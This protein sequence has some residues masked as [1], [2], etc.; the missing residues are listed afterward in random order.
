MRKLFN[1]LKPLVAVLAVLI[2]LLVSAG[3]AR[4][5]MVK[6]DL[7]ELSVD[8]D[9]IV[10]G[11]I[12]N[13]TSHWSE[14][15][16]NIYTTVVVSVEE[17]IKGSQTQ[18]TVTIVVPGGQVDN[19]T[20]FVSDTPAFNLGEEALLFLK[21]LPGK[22]IPRRQIQPRF[23]E[24]SGNFQG[25]KDI[26]R[27]MV[28][29]I[30]VEA[31]EEEISAILEED[32]TDSSVDF[33]LNDPEF[34]SYNQYVYLGIRWPGSSPIV[35]YLVNASS[36]QTTQINAAASTWS[37]A[38]AAFDFHYAGS[39]SRSGQSAYNG[40]NEI[41]WYDL[42]TNNALAIASL[43]FSGSIIL[44][45]DMTFNTRY[46]WSTTSGIY[47][48][49]TVALHEFGHW[50]GLD[51]SPTY[52]SAIYFQY[53][54]TQHYLHSVDIAGIRSIYG[55]SGPAPTNDNFIGRITLSGSSGQTAE[56]NSNAT[57][58]IGEPNHAGDSGGRSV[59]W[60]WTAPANGRVEFDTFG[61]SFDTLLAVYSGTSLT[62]LTAIV[63]NDDYGGLY[64]SKIAFNTLEGT[65]YLIAVDGWAGAAGSIALNWQFT[66]TPCSIS[67]PSQPTGPNVGYTDTTYTFST[68]GSTCVNGHA[69]E[70]HF[71][72]GVGSVSDWSSS[73]D[74]S[75]VWTT[76]ETYQV[77]S[78]V[79]CAVDTEKVSLWSPPI[80]IVIAVETVQH[81]LTVAVEGNGT[82]NPS[83]GAYLYNEGSS[84]DLEAIPDEGWQFAKW[85]IGSEEIFSA[86]TTITLTGD[87]TALA[88]FTETPPVPGDLTGDDPDSDPGDP[89]D[90]VEDTVLTVEYILIIEVEG[91]G[92]T[93]PVAGNYPYEEGSLV[94]LE[95]IPDEGW[96]FDKWVIGSEEFKVESMA[97]TIDSDITLLAVF[98]EVQVITPDPDP[99]PPPTAETPP[100][101]IPNP[102][103]L[104][105]P[106]SPVQYILTLAIRGEGT[107]DPDPGLYNIGENAEIILTAKPTGGWRFEKWVI[108]GVESS[109]INVTVKMSGNKTATAHFGKFELGDITGDGEITV[110]D[111]V[112]VARHTLGMTSLTETQLANADVNGDSLVDIR[113]ITLIMRFALGIV[114]SFPAN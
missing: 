23:Y 114:D 110:S 3:E 63:S 75:R 6:M 13:A 18:N 7:E 41:M 34:V 26:N 10:I 30:P 20:Q 79:R 5:V 91:Q 9:S 92:S 94:D 57:K 21:E 61:S 36:A 47:D 56:N 24:L 11:T 113:D 68:G 25:K 103:V 89:A 42:G 60:A 17:N 111:V 45:T 49:Q 100:P 52:G 108:D 33:A 98:S 81:T 14:D 8:A 54:G 58:E 22:P 87:L 1:L 69:I 97:I 107:T 59:W 64:Q 48:V 38:G 40:T 50:V 19:I 102:P 80:E 71:D 73:A 51:H 55:A 67:T 77:K 88:V 84:V 46:Y 96:C 93:T 16:S 104:T 72:W 105:S 86:I 28:K 95:A 85:V 112:I 76:P 83:T 31:L 101:E 78:Q 109:T 37:N 70:Y 12:E 39:H 44:E 43:W 27:G 82:T 35:S 106:P 32:S 90:P 62:G 74:A 66:P 4:A 2:I 15:Y 65:N 99:A 29:G 53:K